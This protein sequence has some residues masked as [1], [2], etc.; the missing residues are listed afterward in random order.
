MTQRKYKPHRDQEKI[1]N[2][3]DI[4]KNAP[5]QGELLRIVYA[6]MTHP[7]WEVAAPNARFGKLIGFLLILLGT[8]ILI[9]LASVSSPW[10]LVIV[11]TLLFFVIGWIRAGSSAS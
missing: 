6:V 8:T 7:I 2:N 5:E 9:V 1:I 10:P 11:T 3:P 4:R